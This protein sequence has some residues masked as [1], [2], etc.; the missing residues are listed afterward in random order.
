MNTSIDTNIDTNIDTTNN[1]INI[2]KGISKEEIKS[3]INNRLDFIYLDI[4]KILDNQFIKNYTENLNINYL[5]N[6]LQYLTNIIILLAEMN[7]YIMS[8]EKLQLFL[9][10]LINIKIKQSI[11]IIINCLE[12]IEINY[13]LNNN[14]KNLLENNDHMELLHLLFSIIKNH[15]NE[16]DFIESKENEKEDMKNELIKIFKEEN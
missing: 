14:G 13:K 11:I 3:R 4:L 5:T 8:K 12:E 6:I 2:I 16:I 10:S 7:I 1:N 9:N 15:N